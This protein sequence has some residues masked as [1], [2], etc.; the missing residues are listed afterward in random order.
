MADEKRLLQAERL[1]EAV[2]AA[3]LVGEASVA[4]VGAGR[5][6][7]A[8]AV[9]RDQPVAGAELVEERVEEMMERAAEPVDEED[10]PP[11]PALDIVDAVAVDRDELAGGRDG[12]LGAPRD[13]AR[14]E[15]E[16]EPGDDRCGQERR[17]HADD[18]RQD[19]EHAPSPLRSGRA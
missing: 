4:A 17:Q 2:D 8:G 3:R 14:D 12:L 18:H 9:E 16:V 5:P 1:H 10:R 19:F 7:G 13:A 11:L 6:A 15:L